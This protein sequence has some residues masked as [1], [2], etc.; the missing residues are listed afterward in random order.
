LQEAPTG[1]VTTFRSNTPRLGFGKEKYYSRINWTSHGDEPGGVYGAEKSETR[2]LAEG[3]SSN[4]DNE[5]V[6]NI[7]LD[8]EDEGKGKQE[9]EVQRQTAEC[10]IAEDSR[11]LNSQNE[12]DEAEEIERQADEII[13]QPEAEPR[14][15]FDD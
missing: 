11:S 5:S 10:A 8:S 15:I 13:N 1:V 6:K 12:E 9:I 4:T 2:A 14:D 7:Q 3:S